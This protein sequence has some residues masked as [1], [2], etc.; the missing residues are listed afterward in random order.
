MTYSKVLVASLVC[1]GV[2]FTCAVLFLNY[3]GHDVSDAL[4][5]TFL[6]F[7]FGELGFSAWIYNTKTKSQERFEEHWADGGKGTDNE[8][9]EDIELED[10]ADL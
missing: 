1:L 5:Y 2:A 3:S 7:C 9:G 10:E 4:I 8:E 6:G